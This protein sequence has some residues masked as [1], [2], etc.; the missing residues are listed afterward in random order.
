MLASQLPS[1]IPLPFASSG[2]KNTIPTASQIG[3]TAGAASLAD[4]FPPL[5]FTPISSGGVPPSGA[6]FN[7][8]LN[9][10]T[11][12]QQWQSAGGIF[13]YDAAFSTSVGGYPKGAVLMSSTNASTWLNLVDNNTT[14]PDAGG[15]NWISLSAG[16]LIGIRA[17]STPGAYTYTPTT[18]TTS[19]VAEV[20]GGGGAG[21]GAVATNSVTT[22]VAPGGNGGAYGKGRYTT[23]FSG[24]TV[25]VGAGGTGVGGGSG[26]AGGTSSFGG[27][28]SA[29]GGA[30]GPFAPQL[31]TPVIAPNTGA[32]GASVGGNIINAA[33]GAGAPGIAT[34]MGAGASGAGG[35]SV[36]G[37]GGASIGMGSGVAAPGAAANSPGAG[38]SGASCNN[39][40]G[41]AA[42]GSGAGG[43]VII[44]EYA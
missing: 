11:A 5:T 2:T 26:S 15:A 20:V 42:G 14:D 39:N 28:L 19:V 4:G 40:A 33:G 21:G 17:Y 13:K 41:T 27:L 25:T 1:K 31:G 36:L 38:G 32:N 24:V 29:P 37:A 22:S 10:I 3:I 44:Y 12:V 18:G 7:G 6:D 16:R 9:L 30:G 8:I 35:S 23:G 34:S 43:I